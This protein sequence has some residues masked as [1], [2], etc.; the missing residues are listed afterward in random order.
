[1]SLPRPIVVRAELYGPQTAMLP[2]GMDKLLAEI[3][4]GTKAKQFDGYKDFQVHAGSSRGER[5]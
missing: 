3:A 4:G 5:L 2:M 1:M